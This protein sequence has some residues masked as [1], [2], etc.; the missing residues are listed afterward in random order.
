MFVISALDERNKFCCS[1]LGLETL[2]DFIC[3]L[4]IQYLLYQLQAREIKQFKIFKTC[5]EYVKL[6]KTR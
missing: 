2:R 3:V 6:L 4:E 1:V 5:L